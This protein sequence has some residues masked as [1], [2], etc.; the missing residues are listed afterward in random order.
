[1]TLSLPS[2]EEK[3]GWE[4]ARNGSRSTHATGSGAC[5]DPKLLRKQIQQ[6][7]R[8]PVNELWLSPIST[9]GRA[10]L[11]HQGQNPA[12]FEIWG[13]WIGHA[14]APFQEAPPTD[15]IALASRQ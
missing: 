14:T 10:G 2:D 15:E 8:D 13:E 12:A 6:E 1:M 5:A 9:I 3:N 7:L 4:A 11:S